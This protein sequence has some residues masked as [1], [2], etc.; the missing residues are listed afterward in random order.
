MIYLQIA[1]LI[2]I[3]YLIGAIPTSIWVGRLFFNI[4]IREYG[5]GNAGATNFMRV[6]GV[7]VGLP[8]LIFDIFKG[9]AAV[10]C[11]HLFSVYPPQTDSYVNLQI[12]LG[13]AAVI[14]HIY[15]VYVGFRGGKGVATV[16]GVLL[17]LHPLA[18]LCAAGVFILTL[19]I[20]RYVSVSSM[21]AGISFPVWLWFV[22]N[23]PFVYLRFFSILVSVLLI[24]THMK[25]IRKLI[26][27]EEKKASFLFGN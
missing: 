25:N 12:F 14:G 24:L 7:R 22:F 8:V 21:I 16:F 27:G 4:D 17:A 19:L 11:I 18:T 26:S 15:P 2:G 10:Y 5:S 9:W 13:I 1:A 6:L 23:S 3:A 20:T